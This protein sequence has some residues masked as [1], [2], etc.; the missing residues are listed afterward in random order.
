MSDD[1]TIRLAEVFHGPMDLLLHLVREQEVEIQEVELAKV[2]DGYF[3]YLS[4]LE[5]LEIEV[6]GDFLVMAATLMAIKSR[7]LLPREEVEL[8]DELNPEDELLQ[9]LIEYRRFRAAADDLDDREREIALQVLLGE[10]L[11]R[12]PDPMGDKVAR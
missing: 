5:E 12:D 10:S 7:S 2:I 9:R 1:Y 11:A 6:A 3:E 8:E 4:T